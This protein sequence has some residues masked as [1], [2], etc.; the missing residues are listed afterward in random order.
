MNGCRH[1]K[2]RFH[3]PPLAHPIGSPLLTYRSHFSLMPSAVF[4]SLHGRRRTV[5]LLRIGSSQTE[6]KVLAPLGSGGAWLSASGTLRRSAWREAI[7]S[8][9]EARGRCLEWHR[10]PA[11]DKPLSHQASPCRKRLAPGDPI[12]PRH[13]RVG[14]AVAEV[15]AHLFVGRHDHRHVANLQQL[16]KQLQLWA[17]LEDLGEHSSATC[18]RTL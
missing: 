9:R 12:R 16:S 18:C 7:I 15:S 17:L 8:W 2:G 13:S 11:V 3:G 1:R 14:P 5:Q 10:I 6:M 4:C